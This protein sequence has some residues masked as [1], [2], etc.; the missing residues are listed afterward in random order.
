[1]ARR[2][3]RLGGTQPHNDVNTDFRTLS[4]IALRDRIL[5]GDQDAARWLFEAHFD[6]LYEF[7]HYRLGGERAQAE[8]VVQDTF[9]VALES[10]ASFDGRSSLHTWLC[11]IAKNKVRALR[12]KR[13]PAPL[14]DVLDEADDEIDAVLARVSSEPLPDWA[15]ER[16]ET[17]EL[18]GATLSSLPPDY[19]RALVAKYV[20]G[21]SVAQI[22]QDVGRSEKAAESLLTRARAAFGE[23]FELLARKRGGEA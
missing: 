20:S 6:A 15:L 17:R 8:D 23:V 14:A 4:E 10:L 22:A 5:A 13:R 7:A 18:V 2:N 12:R 21:R 9:V 3:A 19:R 11:G 16:K 1:M